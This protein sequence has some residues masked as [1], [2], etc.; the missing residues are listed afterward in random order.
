MVDLPEEVIME[1]PEEMVVVKALVVMGVEEPFPPAPPALAEPEPDPPEPPDALVNAATAEAVPLVT[2]AGRVSEGSRGSEWSAPTVAV[3][4]AVG[5]DD[6][7]LRGTASLVTAV[8]KT[9]AKLRV[10]AVAIRVTSRAAK[11]R[12]A[13]K[14]ASDAALLLF[15]SIHA[16]KHSI[17][18][19]LTPQELMSLGR[20]WAAARAPRAR[21]MADFIVDDV[22]E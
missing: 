17:G 12:C 11:G 13:G 8:A 16:R 2:M 21:M 4:N 15:L 9:E 19:G 10:V 22:V 18:T 3:A 1:P 14:H 5:D 6:L 7:S 20:F